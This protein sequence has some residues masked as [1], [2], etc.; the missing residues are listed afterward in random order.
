MIDYNQKQAIEG[1]LSEFVGIKDLQKISNLKL[2]DIVNF[3]IEN[4]KLYPMLDCSYDFY[5]DFLKKLQKNEYKKVAYVVQLI[6]ICYCRDKGLDLEEIVND[7]ILC[8]IKEDLETNFENIFSKKEIKKAK[9]NLNKSKTEVQSLANS[10]KNK[11]E[12]QILKTPKGNNYV[13]FINEVLEDIEKGVEIKEYNSIDEM[14]TDYEKENNLNDS[15]NNGGKTDYYKLD[16]KWEMVQDIIEDRNMNFSQGNIL[17]AAFCFNTN[18]HQGT[19]YEREL[20]KII[21]FAERELKRIKHL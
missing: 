18:R 4:N 10:L 7:F 6:F 20:N 3:V 8:D 15:H 12:L 9:E 2:E 1:T 13:D 19:N 17:K 21:Y 16:K 14:R 5:C 11:G